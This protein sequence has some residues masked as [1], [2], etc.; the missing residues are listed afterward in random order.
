V[1]RLLG[2]PDNEEPFLLF[3]VGYA[4]P[5]ATVP[6]IVRKRAGEILQWNRD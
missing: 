6:D 3:P 1:N 4:S 5:D 2:R